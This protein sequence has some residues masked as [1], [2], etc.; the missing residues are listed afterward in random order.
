MGR[1]AAGHPFVV[2]KIRKSEFQ[3][4]EPLVTVVGCSSNPRPNYSFARVSTP[5]SQLSKEEQYRTYK[6]ATH[7]PDDLMY[8]E[9][10]FA[11]K[12]SYVLRDHAFEIP[13]SHI[14]SFFYSQGQGTP[15]MRF[16]NDSYLRLMRMM[17]LE[18]DF[19][20]PTASAIIIYTNNTTVTRIISLPAQNYSLLRAATP[21]F[22]PR[23]VLG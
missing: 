2:L 12:D 14:R 16:T 9:H 8:L 11:K 4:T 7:H 22:M 6:S 23:V 18:P 3:D 21:L 1:R 10:G 5:I 17:N 15:A 20:V 13:L 19:W